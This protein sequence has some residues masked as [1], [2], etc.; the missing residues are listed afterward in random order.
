MKEI[1][2]EE[3]EEGFVRISKVWKEESSEEEEEE[4]KEVKGRIRKKFVI[5]NK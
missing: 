3:E 1:S 5:K 4:E 2:E